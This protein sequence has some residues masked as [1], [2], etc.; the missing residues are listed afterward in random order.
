MNMKKDRQTLIL[1]LVSSEEIATQDELIEQLRVRGLAVTQA[2]ISRDIRELK[3]TKIPT[4]VGS[5]RYVAP[6]SGDH[7]GNSA[8][9]AM[10]AGAVRSVVASQNIIVLRTNSGL[11]QPVALGIDNLGLSEILGCVAGDDTVIAVARDTES[12]AETALRLREMLKS[13]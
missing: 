7:A 9:R 6:Q 1:D 11:A 4:G 3:L 2:T 12:A 10:I 5:Y 13:V 8:F